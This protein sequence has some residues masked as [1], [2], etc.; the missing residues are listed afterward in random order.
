V[1]IEPTLQGRIEEAK[2]SKSRRRKRNGALQQ[3]RDVSTERR[4][5][6]K[7]R[8]WDGSVFHDSCH[9]R[10]TALCERG[11]KPNGNRNPR[12]HMDE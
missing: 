1:E 9:R 7:E 5:K 10:H 6:D 4:R 11:W 3:S 12:W 8:R 2:V